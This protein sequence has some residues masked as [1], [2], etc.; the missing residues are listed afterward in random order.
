MLVLIHWVEARTPALK[1]LFLLT[2]LIIA[3]VCGSATLL[4]IF[5]H[6]PAFG[7]ILGTFMSVMFFVFFRSLFQILS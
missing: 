6:R 3:V 5:Y 4:L 1:A 7:G 2:W